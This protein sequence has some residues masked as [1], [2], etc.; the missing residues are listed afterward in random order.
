MNKLLVICGPTATGKT[1][2]GI[3]LAKKFKGE[4]VSA[5]SRQVYKYMNIGTGKDLNKFSIFNFQFSIKDNYKIGYH[6]V[7]S[8]PIWLYDVV[9]PDYR[10]SVADYMKCANLVIKD[11]WKR[12][13]LP[14]LVGGTGLYIKAVIDGIETIG[15]KPDWTLRK[16][17]SNYQITKLPNLLRKI[18]SERWER[19]NQ[20]DR[21]NPRRLV[22]AIEIA[23]QTQNSKLKTQNYNSKL[24]T[25]KILLI[26]L[27]TSYEVLYKRID[28]RVEKRVKEGIVEEIKGLLR[29][30]YAWKNS[31]VG[32]TI[33]YKEWKNYFMKTLKH[34]NIKTKLQDE[35]IQKWKYDEHSYARRQMTW[36]KKEFQVLRQA[37]DKHLQKTEGVWFDI[38]QKEWENDLM[39]FLSLP[40]QG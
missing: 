4:I 2:V 26:G 36:F 20:S 37:Q 38:C 8:V 34:E 17:L 3:K 39:S 6:L 32:E 11:I 33:G 1:A 7:D 10:F 35:T 31:V 16:E 28:R 13:K 25:D 15:I 22:R 30:G 23:K 18:D 40:S 21:Q 27:R 19:M 5:D 29:K 9:K 24:K 12:K 14:I